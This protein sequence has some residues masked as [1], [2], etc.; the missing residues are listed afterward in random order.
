MFTVTFKTGHQLT[1]HF[2]FYNSDT[3][4][5]DARKVVADD[6]ELRNILNNTTIK[7]DGSMVRVFYGPVAQEVACFMKDAWGV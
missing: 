6:I 5:M 2:G 1:G 3:D 4:P 7:N